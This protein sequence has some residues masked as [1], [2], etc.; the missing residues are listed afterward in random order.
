M[1]LY[2]TLSL[3]AA[4]SAA[5]SLDR[6]EADLAKF[7]GEIAALEAE[8]AKVPGDIRSKDWVKKKL[9]HMSAVDQHL[10]R[11]WDLPSQRGYNEAEK[12][13]FDELFM[14]RWTQIDS[15]NT[16]ELKLLLDVYGWIKASEFGEQ[17][18][19][20]AWLLAQH[21]DLDLPF[22]KR[23][24]ALLEAAHKSG[25]ASGA[26]YA[27]LHDRVAV[28]EK[29][30]QRYGTQGR[31]TG[32]GHWEPWDSERPDELDAR[33]HALGLGP[34]AEYARRVGQSYCREADPREAK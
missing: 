26:D 25:E 1:T 34:A 3:A 22:Q 11:N 15:R 33:R 13:R 9:S 18:S 24:L 19:H 8:F 12:R 27:Y 7:D 31:C 5:A 10:R 28:A 2:A 29:R 23:V 21:A 16:A 6:V 4:M 17:A 32:P 20:D 30:P 14:R